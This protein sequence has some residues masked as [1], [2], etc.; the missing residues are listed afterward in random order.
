[1][2]ASRNYLITGGTS[3]IGETVARHLTGHGHTVWVTGT[4]ADGVARAIHEQFATGGSVA[5]V[6]VAETVEFAF[7]QA[8]TE[9]GSLH[10]AFLN[11]GIDGEAKPAAELDANN[12]ARVLAVNTVGVLTSAQAA[13]RHLERPGQIVVN[14]SVNALRPEAL[15]A[16]YNASKAAT[17]SIAKS[18]ALEWSA[19]G[20]GVVA[21]CPGYFESRM[22]APYL[23]DPAVVAEL[24]HGVPARRFGVP[25]DIGS[26]LEF[27][28]GPNAS[29]LTGSTISLDGGR[30][31]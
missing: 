17:L 21:I 16:D 3:G 25:N 2:N 10:G 5:D 23:S 31:L 22:T 7:A 18:L 13:H 19:K 26:L 27:L 20:L 14:A 12:F 28:L 8:C 24:L 4:T 9:L 1:M 6:T 29:Y 15:F 11:A 30:S